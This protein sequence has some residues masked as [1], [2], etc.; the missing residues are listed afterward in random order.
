MRTLAETHH[1]AG[2]LLQF[3]PRATFE[4]GTS[5]HPFAK[6]G[7]TWSVTGTKALGYTGEHQ[8]QSWQRMLSPTA[9]AENIIPPDKS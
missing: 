5:L 2:W 8:E 7:I 3:V 4:P 1:Q 9:A 6:M